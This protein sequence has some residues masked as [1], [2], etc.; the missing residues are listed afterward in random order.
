[1]G[2][3]IEKFVRHRNAD[4]GVII[5]IS[6]KFKKAILKMIKL[7]LVECGRIERV[8]LT[9]VIPPDSESESEC[10]LKRY[11]HGEPVDF[12]NTAPFERHRAPLTADDHDDAAESHQMAFFS[13]AKLDD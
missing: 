7:W 13:I 11:Q 5:R 1:M 6:Q 4:N 3:K 10:N 9:R 8:K 2:S 12:Q